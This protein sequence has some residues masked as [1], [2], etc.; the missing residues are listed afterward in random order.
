MVGFGRKQGFITA[1]FFGFHCR[2]THETNVCFWHKSG[3]HGRAHPCPLS[4]VKRTSGRLSEMSAYDPEWTL[5]RYM[6]GSKIG[7]L[8]GRG[9]SCDNLPDCKCVEPIERDNSVQS[10]E[11]AHQV[12]L[13]DCCTGEW[14]EMP[15][16]GAFRRTY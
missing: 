10:R 4:G 6:L 2:A 14:I 9:G 7:L 5:L 15:C 3:H 13:S 16:Y 11:G 1:R 8:V 12:C